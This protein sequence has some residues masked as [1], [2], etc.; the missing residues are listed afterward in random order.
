MCH[1]HIFE[2]ANK[3]FS[4]KR[5]VNEMGIVKCNNLQVQK[6]YFKLCVNLNIFS[7]QVR[8]LREKRRRKMDAREEEAAAV[9][10]L[11]ERQKTI[12]EDRKKVA[13]LILYPILE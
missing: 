3:Q 7:Y 9:L 8:Q 2:S 6:K 13:I 5:T 1:C 4:C 10:G 11:G 12:V